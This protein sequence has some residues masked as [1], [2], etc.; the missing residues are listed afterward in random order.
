MPERKG[1]LQSQWR[2]QD[3]KSGGASEAE[4]ATMGLRAYGGARTCA[5]S[6]HSEREA[7]ADFMSSVALPSNYVPPTL[8]R[9]TLHINSFRSSFLGEI[10]G[11]CISVRGPPSHVKAA[12]LI[13]PSFAYILTHNFTGNFAGNFSFKQDRFQRFRP[14]QNYFNSLKKKPVYFDTQKIHSDKNASGCVR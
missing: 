14:Y 8:A 5:R 13:S 11:T 10:H 2:H 9:K 4:G 3:L 12:G 7:R 1:R 6:A